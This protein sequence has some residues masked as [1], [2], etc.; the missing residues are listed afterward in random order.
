MQKPNLE[1]SWGAQA[2]ASIFQA[3]DEENVP[4]LS[5][6]KAPS[7]SVPVGHVSKS[8]ATR[9][10]SSTGSTQSAKISRLDPS[11]VTLPTQHHEFESDLSDEDAKKVEASALK[12]DI[13]RL[14]TEIDD[15]KTELEEKKLQIQRLRTE[16]E[17][18]KTAT[19][20]DPPSMMNRLRPVPRGELTSKHRRR[21]VEQSDFEESE[22]GTCTEYCCTS[23]KCVT[24]TY[25]Y[26]RNPQ[27]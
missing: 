10:V 14:R 3:A 23:S 19:A 11:S 25:R 12:L 16:L 7:K 13:W 26:L 1:I 5:L 6:S 24:N 4:E 22:Q 9:P 20:S 2:L 18:A 8:V 21:N 15:L 27:C 17:E